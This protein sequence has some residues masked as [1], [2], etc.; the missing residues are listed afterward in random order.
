MEMLMRRRPQNGRTW[1]SYRAGLLGGFPN[2]A[3]LMLERRFLHTIAQDN[4]RPPPT[5]VQMTIP[6]VCRV[7]SLTE[8]PFC[9]RTSGE[10]CETGASGEVLRFARRRHRRRMKHRFGLP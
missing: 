5:S 1:E 10:A 4:I 6:A 9:S 2:R 3:L 8:V 7:S